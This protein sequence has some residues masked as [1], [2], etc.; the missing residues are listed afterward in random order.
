MAT[1]QSSSREW[2]LF[3]ISWNLKVMHVDELESKAEKL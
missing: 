1:R 3:V 2:Q